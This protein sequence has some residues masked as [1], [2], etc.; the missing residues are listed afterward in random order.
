MSE[1]LLSFEKNGRTVIFTFVDLL[2]VAWP[3]FQIICHH[4]DGFTLEV[5]AV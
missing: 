5:S 3:S 2:V 1:Q 4:C